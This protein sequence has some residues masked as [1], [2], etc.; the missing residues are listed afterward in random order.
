MKTR[1]AAC[2]CGQLTATINAEP[3]RISVCHCLACQRRTGSVFGM[4][5]RFPAS[6]VEITG[7]SHQYQ[8]TGDSGGTAEFHFCPHC[9]AI[10]YYRILAQPEVL[11]IPVGVFADP[12]FPPP[13]VAVYM[14]RKHPWVQMPAQCE[15]YD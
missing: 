13:T 8:R 4:Q 3:V 7:K 11:A 14:E 5:A 9:A 1:H 2:S 12:S 15:L 6:A 10:V